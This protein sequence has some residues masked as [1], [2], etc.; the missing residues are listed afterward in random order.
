MTYN[1]QFDPT[2]T[3]VC[4]VGVS[5][6]PT[7]RHVPYLIPYI[8]TL[9]SPSR[10][11]REYIYMPRSYS[12]KCHFHY[13]KPCSIVWFWAYKW[14]CIVRISLLHTDNINCSTPFIRV[15]CILL[16]F[17][18]LGVHVCFPENMRGRGA[19]IL[20]LPIWI[21]IV[22]GVVEECSMLEETHTQRKHWSQTKH[23]MPS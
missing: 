23:N 22:Q 15:C 13:E 8:H 10:K 12:T 16:M 2:V 9:L 20:K 11:W 5:E 1:S 19:R 14:K 7:I 3:I 21:S 6:V 18:P 17:F 4:G